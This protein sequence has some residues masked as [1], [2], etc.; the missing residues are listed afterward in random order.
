MDAIQKSLMEIKYSIPAEILSDVFLTHSN[1]SP[2]VSLDEQLRSLV[3]KPRVLVDCD[4]VGG[5]MMHVPISNCQLIHHS[6]DEMVL[7]VPKTL[8]NGKS[9]MS[10]MSVSDRPVD[11]GGSDGSLVSAAE[12][13]MSSSSPSG[14][15]HSGRIELVA[16]NTVLIR[17]Y[18]SFGTFGYITIRVGN[19]ANM[20][21]IDPRSYG[22]FTRLV[23]LAVKSYVYNKLRISFRINSAMGGYDSGRVDA[24]IDELSTAEEE[25]GELLRNVWGKVA[26]INDT[27]S[28]SKFI[29]SM[30]SPGL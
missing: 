16:E 2:N 22:V 7:F 23:V 3:I 14:T 28:H 4:L 8:T 26:T 15:A 5:I 10:A 6:E 19:D 1:Y 24:Y 27:Q 25:Y 17:D 30:V 9:I 29:R 18:M 12:R 11:G 21:N 20:S 13:M